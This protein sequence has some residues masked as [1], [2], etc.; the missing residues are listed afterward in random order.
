MRMFFL[1]CLQVFVFSI[2]CFLG[3]RDI[4]AD[5]GELTI[6]SLRGDNLPFMYMNVRVDGVDEVLGREDFDVVDNGD[7]VSDDEYFQVIAPD[8]HN[9]IRLVDVVFV[10]DDSR[11]MRNEQ[12]AIKNN[13]GSFVQALDSS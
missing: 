8:G 6:D 10:F 12:Q 7:V 4:S 13:I 3:G 2:F 11:S 5:S 9:Q 1:F